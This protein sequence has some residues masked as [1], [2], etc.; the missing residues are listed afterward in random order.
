LKN[1]DLDFS[2]R[3]DGFDGHRGVC[4]ECINDKNRNRKPKDNEK[5]V[6]I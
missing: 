5:K 3:S 6:L 2:L 1:I 4:K